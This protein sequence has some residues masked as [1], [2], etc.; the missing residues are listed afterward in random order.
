[1]HFYVI[2][3]VNEEEGPSFGPCI[4]KACTVEWALVA[5][6]HAL[7]AVLH[8]G[9]LAVAMDCSIANSQASQLHCLLVRVVEKEVHFWGAVGES[10]FNVAFDHLQVFQLLLQLE[11]DLILLVVR[12]SATIV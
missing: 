1:V 11:R 7:D 8:F 4:T 5:L 12:L 10:L 3:S 6:Q 9:N 2:S